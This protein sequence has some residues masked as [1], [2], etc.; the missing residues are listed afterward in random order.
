MGRQEQ[1]RDEVIE[2]GYASVFKSFDVWLC[3]FYPESCVGFIL[4]LFSKA[5]DLLLAGEGEM[6]SKRMSL[7]PWSKL[8]VARPEPQQ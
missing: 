4:K 1:W 8:E 3:G 5:K 2:Q 7:Q 6:G